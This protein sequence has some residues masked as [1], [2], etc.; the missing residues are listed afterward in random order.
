MVVN[1]YCNWPTYSPS[2][3]F[4]TVATDLSAYISSHKMSLKRHKDREINW[5]L[6]GFNLFKSLT[7]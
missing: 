1:D 6:M 3:L 5:V 4:H 2:D 7:N